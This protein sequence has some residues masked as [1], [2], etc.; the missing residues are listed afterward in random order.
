MGGD[1]VMNTLALTQVIVAIIASIQNSNSLT[2]VC[3]HRMVFIVA[4]ESVAYYYL[5]KAM[6]REIVCSTKISPHFVGYEW[7][8]RS[9]FII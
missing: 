7:P 8:I 3:F 2:E 5:I 4:D 1:V 6:S 9:F